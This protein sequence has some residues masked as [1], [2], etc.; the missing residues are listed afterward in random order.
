MLGLLGSN[1]QQQ[2]EGLISAF[3][4]FSLSRKIDFSII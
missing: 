1:N 2:K 3:L 4:I